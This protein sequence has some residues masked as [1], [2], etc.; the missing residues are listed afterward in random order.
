MTC[1]CVFVAKT[2][3]LEFF[4]SLYSYKEDTS[5]CSK[6]VRKVKLLYMDLR[7]IMIFSYFGLKTAFEKGC[8]SLLENQ[9]EPSVAEIWFFR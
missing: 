5:L 7:S 6:I 4:C 8:F 2:F 9:D 1:L 3:S